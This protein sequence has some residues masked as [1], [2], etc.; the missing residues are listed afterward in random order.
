MRLLTHLLATVLLSTAMPVRAQ[1]EPAD[2]AGTE[3][4]PAIAELTK[5]MQ[6][7]DGMLPLYWQPSSGKLFMEMVGLDRGQL[8]DSAVVF[9]DRIGQKV[10]LT[11]GGRRR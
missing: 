7:L 3:K 9:F 8:G 11:I 5:G 2:A 10:L 4:S 6:K 1:N